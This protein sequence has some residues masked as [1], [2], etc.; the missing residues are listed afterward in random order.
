MCKNIR[1]YVTTT[2]IQKNVKNQV[3]IIDIF[4]FVFIKNNFVESPAVRNSVFMYLYIKY[5]KKNMI[6]C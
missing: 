5:I 6:R 1:K 2:K 4:C 3:E